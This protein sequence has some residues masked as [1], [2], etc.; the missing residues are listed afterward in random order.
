[1]EGVRWGIPTCPSLNA[2]QP[3]ASAMSEELEMKP[4]VSEQEGTQ[5]ELMAQLTTTVNRA[6]TEG[7]S[8]KKCNHVH[9]N[10]TKV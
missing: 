1:M 5:L 4:N 8:E 2:E 10:A 9:L 7:K 3:M 6:G